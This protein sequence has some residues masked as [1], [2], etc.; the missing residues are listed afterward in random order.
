M[1]QANLGVVHMSEEDGT[2]VRVVYEQR[3]KLPFSLASNPV[4]WQ[5]PFAMTL[6]EELRPGMKLVVTVSSQVAVSAQLFRKEGGNTLVSAWPHS[7]RLSFEFPVDTAGSYLLKLY[8]HGRSPLADADIKI[9]IK[10]PKP[11]G[12]P[13]SEPLA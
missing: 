3:V 4:A 9:A 11:K 2:E 13:G 8:Q 5:S 10:V 7:T 6:P 12:D 1:I